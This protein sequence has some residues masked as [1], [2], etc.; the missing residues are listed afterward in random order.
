MTF[1]PWLSIVA[2]SACA[3]P[4]TVHG[5]TTLPAFSTF[6]KANSSIQQIATDPSGNIYVV[7]QVPANDQDVFVTKVNPG[8][9][10]FAWIV[11]FGGSSVETAGGLAVDAAGNAYITGSTTSPD[12]PSTPQT[13]GPLPSDPSMQIPFAA[14]VNTNGAIVYSTLFSNGA[15]AVPAAIAVDGSGDAIISGIARETNFTT[16]PDAYNNPWSGNPPFVTKLD[17]TGTKVLFSVVGVGGSSMALDAAN[18]IF[19]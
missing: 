5:Q 8:N 12:F 2:L 1:R 10:G 3:M 7:G 9:A 13:T 11:Y 14:K 17:P 16:T 15:S 18:N 6:L 19:E 4:L